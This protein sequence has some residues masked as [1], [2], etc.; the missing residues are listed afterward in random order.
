MEALLKKISQNTIVIL[1]LMTGA[2]FLFLRFLSPLLSPIL[3]AMLFVTIFG[4][5][6]KKMQKLH[7]HRHVGA[8]VLLLVAL[9]ALGILLW[10]LCRWAWKGFPQ[11][12]VWAESWKQ[13][14]PPWADGWVD[15]GISELGKSVIDLEKGVLGGAFRHAGR[16]VAVGG[17]L[18]TFLIAVILLAKDYDEMMN[19]LLDREDG[20]LLLSVFCSVI[21]Y[22]ATYVKAQGV[23]MT[24]IAGTC[25]LTL[26]IARVP[27]GA[28]FGLLAGALDALPFVGT[29]VVLVPLAVFHVL[30]GHV[31]VGV[32]CGILY[33]ACI[34]L[35]ELMEPKLIGKR[36]GV[37]PIFILI[38]I[39]V[40]IRLFGV[41]GI[42][43]GP[44][45]FVII[46][47][48]WRQTKASLKNGKSGKHVK[49]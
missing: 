7:L 1:L 27:Q 6:L 30:E 18:V 4:P 41:A 37:R 25:A 40:G 14:L 5:L 45:G 29:G 13:K 28:L 8:V 2:V 17:Y 22:L 34:I 44:L 32:T 10:I 24:V 36:M 9:A 15:L 38:S 33:A 26:S 3:V 21:R 19:W 35:R 42:I 23:I 11:V 43:K 16:I 20:R 12:M 47:E 39:Y 46:L 49:K 48:T 31:G